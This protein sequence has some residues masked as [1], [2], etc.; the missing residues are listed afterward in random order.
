MMTKVSGGASAS[1]WQEGS[2]AANKNWTGMTKQWK[3]KNG[4][5]QMPV[6]VVRAVSQKFRHAPP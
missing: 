4:G 2:A 6:K 3:N 5:W 1:R